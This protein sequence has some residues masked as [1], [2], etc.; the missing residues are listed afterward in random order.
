MHLADR[1]GRERFGLEP[2]VN[3]AH[4]AP[5]FAPDYRL[6]VSVGKRRDV[7]EQLEPFVA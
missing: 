5:K 7:V 2:R 3:L 1:R 4:V 6:N